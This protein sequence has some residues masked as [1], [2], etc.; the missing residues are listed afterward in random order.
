M[1]AMIITRLQGR[2]IRVLQRHRRHRLS[3]FQQRADH[4]DQEKR[5]EDEKR[6]L[7]HTKILRKISV[8]KGAPLPANV[9]LGYAFVSL[10]PIG[11]ALMAV[12]C[13]YLRACLES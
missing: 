3:Q 6:M 7:C 11:Y 1:L 5:F 12:A 10:W 9:D 8:S 2:K 4:R 13:S